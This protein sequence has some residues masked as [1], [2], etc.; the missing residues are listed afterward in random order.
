MNGETLL[1]DM[2]RL[3]TGSPIAEIID[4]YYFYVVLGEDDPKVVEDFMGFSYDT[5][6]KFFD[7]FLRTYL[8]TDDEDKIREMTEKASFLCSIRMI[9]KLHKRGE[10]P[11]KDRE[12]LRKN[13]ENTR[14]LADKL[15]S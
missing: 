7:C 9:N 14:A 1:I 5:S 12:I 10:V 4:L 8:D 13:M 2:D 6:L 11:E 3:S 15:L